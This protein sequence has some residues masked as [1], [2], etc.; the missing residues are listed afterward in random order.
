M[1]KPD[2]PLRKRQVTDRRNWWLDATGATD[3]QRRFFE[4]SG[5]DLELADLLVENAVG[6]M[7]VPLGVASG[8]VVNGRNYEVPLATEEPS[9]IAAAS[10]GASLAARAGGFRAGAAD[11][12][13]RAQVFLE[14]PA[15]DAETRLEAHRGALEAEART[16][17]ASM[18]RRGGGLRALSLGRL[19]GLDVAAVRLDVDVRDAMGANLLNTLAEAMTPSLEKTL[20][21]KKLLAIL[22]NDASLRPAWAEVRFPFTSLNKPGIPGSEMARRIALASAVAQADPQRAVTHNKGIMNGISALALA[23]GNDTRAL[24]AAVHSFAAA[25]GSYRG[26]SRWSVEGEFLAGHLDIP[27]ALATVGGSVGIHPTARMALQLL[28]DPSSPEL[29]TLAAALGLA[30]N[31]AALFALAGEGIQ[32]GHMALHDR[33]RDWIDRHNGAKP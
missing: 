19:A 17:M 9:V 31:F 13:M 12:V 16:H 18:E 26:L 1:D 32:R 33:R 30:Q 5:A 24:E 3:G 11:P 20:G 28:G 21:G 10:Y 8:L 14:N 22:S 29:C 4:A 7:P 25:T 15:P 2:P 23:T 27:L 6:W